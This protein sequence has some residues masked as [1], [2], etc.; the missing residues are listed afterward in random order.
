MTTNQKSIINTHTC[1]KRKNSNIIKMVIKSQGKRAKEEQKKKKY[2]SN[3]K[4]I[5]KIEIN[6]YIYNYSKCK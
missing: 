5:N 4:T 2:N 6:K 1:K 3:H